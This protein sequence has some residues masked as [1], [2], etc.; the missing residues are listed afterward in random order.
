[1]T[2]FK[3]S[4]LSILTSEVRYNTGH[5]YHTSELVTLLIFAMFHLQTTEVQPFKVECFSTKMLRFQ[6][7]DVII[8]D[9]SAYFE[10]LFDMLNS[11]I[12]SYPCAKFY[13]DMTINITELIAFVLCILDN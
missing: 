6:Q 2:C 5:L 13:R 3:K 9:V 11:L 8:Y 1:M 4:F 10:I 7:Y 12:M